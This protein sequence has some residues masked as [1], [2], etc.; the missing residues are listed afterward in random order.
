MDFLFKFGVKMD[1][2]SKEQKEVNDFSLVAKQRDLELPNFQAWENRFVAYFSE[3]ANDAAHDLGHF[4]RVATVAK[5]IAA[6]EAVEV[7]I[8]VLL[9]AAYFHDI[10]SLPKN[11]PDNKFSSKLAAVQARAILAEMSFPSKKIEGVC[12]AIEAHSYSAQIEP[13]TKEAKIIQDADRMEAL[14][15]IG[16]LRTFYIAGRLG[17]ELFDSNDI[18]AERRS[19]DDK[20]FALDHFYCKLFKLS[21]SIQTEGGRRIAQSRDQFMHLFVKDLMMDI[22]AGK[23]GALKLVYVCSHAGQK[24]LGLFDSSDPFA[25]KRELS[26]G[27]FVV[28]QLLE[29]NTHFPKFVTSFLAQL[30]EEI[31]IG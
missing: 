24:G 8:L 13:K 21:S 31:I 3:H 23:G 5:K 25:A 29:I 15:A 26:S 4:R 30:E 27:Q 22:Q 11:H 2:I 6:C 14:G 19:L 28:D 16:V 1:E 17:I 12:H 10:V 9:A 18:F 20:R 7:D